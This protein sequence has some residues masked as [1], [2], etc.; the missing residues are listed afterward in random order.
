MKIEL[1][2]RVAVVTG[3]S[4]GIGR[5]VAV[6]LASAG[7]SVACVASKEANAQATVDAI[8]AAGGRAEAF[9]CDV[10]R[11]SDIT[12]LADAVAK[13]FGRVD[14]LVNNAGI[15]RDG[16]L[17]RMSEEDWDTV[18]DTNLKGA[19]LVVK[20]FSRHLLRSKCGRVINIASVVGISGNGGQANYAASKGG[21]IA[22]TKSVSKEIGSR[23]ITANAVAPGF[24]ATDMT[25]ALTAEQRDAMVK[26]ITL[27][28]TGT[29]DDVAGVVTWLA[30]DLAAYVTG[31]VI[32]VDGGLRL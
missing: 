21:L 23:G 32:A 27:A 31:Q 20:A 6:A 22:F 2:E 17:M 28:R 25:D 11:P 4:R 14:I 10:G 7:A 30:S 12:A 19:F 16:L 5:A 29:P 9:G 8:R 26:G 1:S 18:L 3:A 15:T 24:I 13:S